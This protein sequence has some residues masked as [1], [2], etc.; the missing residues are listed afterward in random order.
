LYVGDK[1]YE[2]TI[3]NCSK[4]ELIQKGPDVIMHLKNREYV[5]TIDC[6]TKTEDFILLKGPCDDQMA[7]L[8]QENLQGLVNVTLKETSGGRIFYNDNGRCSGVEY[9]GEQM[10]VLDQ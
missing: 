10:M 4:T 2:F 6:K 1:F 8:V 5:L 9:G 7:Q 3:M